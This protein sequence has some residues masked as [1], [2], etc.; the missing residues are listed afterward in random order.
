MA[1]KRKRSYSAP[2]SSKRGRFVRRRRIY[3]RKRVY[4]PRRR[5]QPRSARKEIKQR[6]LHIPR[7]W[8][9]KALATFDFRH[10]STLTTGASGALDTDFYY[11][12]QCYQ[13]L[14]GT[15]NPAGFNTLVGSI[16]ARYVVYRADVE[17]VFHNESTA[18][19]IQ[20]LM[21]AAPG[22]PTLAGLTPKQ[23]FQFARNQYTTVWQVDNETVGG[24]YNNKRFKANYKMANLFGIP[25]GDIYED[26]YQVIG[27]TGSPSQGAYF[28][29]GAA[30]KPQAATAGVTV[31]YEI[32]IR[33]YCKLSDNNNNQFS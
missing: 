18:S 4:Y 1:Y 2:G 15:S 33:Y 27:P 6:I 12:N 9:A 31:D 23:V 5:S 24:G 22:L 10:A 29:I 16:Y 28:V 7:L 3:R 25:K 19:E 13:T 11:L 30:S 14:P 8:P 21:H 20:V 32:Y 26:A 17:V